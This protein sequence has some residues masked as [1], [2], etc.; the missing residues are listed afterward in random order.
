MLGL[1]ILQAKEIAS[2]DAD[3][4]WAEFGERVGMIC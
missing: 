3:G 4:S 1:Q 2:A